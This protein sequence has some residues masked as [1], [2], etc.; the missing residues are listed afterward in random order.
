VA[1]V[2]PLG[3]YLEFRGEGF[4]GQAVAGLGGGGIGQNLS[5]GGEPVRTRGGWGQLLIRP[6]PHWEL[7]G[8]YGVDDPDDGD[9][10][11]ATGRLRNEVW[12]A[13]LQWRPR[14]LVLGAEFRWLRTRYGGGTGT[15]EATHLN[16]ALG[17]EF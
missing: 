3:R 6:G 2:L 4:L 12:V 17:V 15:V 8:S 1:L 10:V 5:P 14:P 16:L 13:E 11:P 9:V 7:G